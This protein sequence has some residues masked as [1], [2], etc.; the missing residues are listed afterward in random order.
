MRSWSSGKCQWR[1]SQRKARGGRVRLRRGGRVSRRGGA[2]G[3]RGA[4]GGREEPKRDAGSP[5][6]KNQHIL[7]VKTRGKG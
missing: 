7:I 3:G 5:T 1:R 6:L 4:R 2:T